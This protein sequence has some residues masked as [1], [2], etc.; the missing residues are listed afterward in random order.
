MLSYF[1]QGFLIGFPTAAQPGP[2]QAYLL[3]ETL[4]KGWKKTFIV[5]FAPLISDGPIIALTLFVLSALPPFFI[6]M[7]RIF[8][9]IYLSYL[10]IT[11]ILHADDSDVDANEQKGV[12]GVKRAILVNMT[13]PG[14]WIFWSSIGGPLLLEGGKISLLNPTGFL[15]GFYTSMVGTFMMYIRFFGFF[16]KLTGTFLSRTRQFSGL[17]LLAFAGFLFFQTIKPL[18]F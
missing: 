5:A 1:I 2:F 13:G 9:G 12:E 4:D 18:F 7:L 11:I 16:E 17:L 6:P 3:N 14:P 10:A 15:L 8:G